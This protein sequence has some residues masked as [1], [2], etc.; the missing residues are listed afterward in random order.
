LAEELSL[1]RVSQLLSLNEQEHHLVIPT[2]LERVAGE[3]QSVKWQCCIPLIVIIL[4]SDE[5]EW[6]AT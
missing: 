3:V 2:V 6:N 4:G 1:A 5:C